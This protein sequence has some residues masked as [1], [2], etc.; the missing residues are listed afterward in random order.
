MEATGCTLLRIDI[1]LLNAPDVLKVMFSTKLIFYGHPPICALRHSNAAWCVF[2]REW[3]VRLGI[4]PVDAVPWSGH[5]QVEETGN[6]IGKQGGSATSEPV[7]KMAG[8]PEKSSSA[9]ELKEQGNRLFLCRKYQ[10]AA[11]CYSKAIVGGESYTM[12]GPLYKDY[13]NSFEFGSWIDGS[14]VPRATHAPVFRWSSFA[15]VQPWHS[16]RP[17]AVLRLSAKV[18][19]LIQYHCQIVPKVSNCLTV[20]IFFFLMN[21]N[22]KNL[23]GLIL[24]ASLR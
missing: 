11:T 8:S 10:E 19:C 5:S 17:T 4:S 9:Q 15:S 16:G 18:W 7:E 22:L 21:S 12:N 1:S 3:E 24:H 2:F 6:R 14:H 13:L 23:V 20:T